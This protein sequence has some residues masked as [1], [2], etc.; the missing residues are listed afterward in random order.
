MKCSNYEISIAPRNE[1]QETEITSILL[2]NAN[3]NNTTRSGVPTSKDHNGKSSQG[4]LFRNVGDK[5]TAGATITTT[6]GNSDSN[7]GTSSTTYLNVHSGLAVGLMAGI[8]VGA[9]CRS[10]YLLV[11]QPMSDVAQAESL[12]GKGELVISPSAHAFLCGSVMRQNE[13]IQ[14]EYEAAHT[15]AQVSVS[16]EGIDDSRGKE[17]STQYSSRH[18]ENVA[19]ASDGSSGRDRDNE[20]TGPRLVS[21]GCVTVADAPGIRSADTDNGGDGDGGGGGGGGAE[22]SK[23]SYVKVSRSR[24]RFE[25]GGVLG[26]D[27]DTD[28][29]YDYDLAICSSTIDHANFA[30]QSVQDT[31]AQLF[32]EEIKHG[33][34]QQQ[35]QWTGNT[36]A[37]AGAGEGTTGKEQPEVVTIAS[38]DAM[39][40]Q[41]SGNDPLY[42]AAQLLFLKHRSEQSAVTAESLQ[43]S[44]VTDRLDAGVT[45]ENSQGF[46]TSHVS[47]IKDLLRVKLLENYLKYAN[48]RL[49]DEF[50]RHVHDVH[51]VNF[52]FKHDLHSG[53]LRQLA[54]NLLHTGCNLTA[55]VAASLSSQ[56]HEEEGEG[57][58]ESSRTT[59]ADWAHHSHSIN[60]SNNGISVGV[61]SPKAVNEHIG[62]GNP[63]HT[64]QHGAAESLKSTSSYSTNSFL[65]D[66]SG[67]ND[68]SLVTKVRNMTK[69][70]KLRESSHEQRQHHHKRTRQLD[71]SLNAELRTVIVLFINVRLGPVELYVEHGASRASEQENRG[72]NVQ[73]QESYEGR[74]LHGYELH[75]V[76]EGFSAGQI[77]DPDAAPAGF[78]G[79]NPV[80]GRTDSGDCCGVGGG[81][82]HS[83]AKERVIDASRTRAQAAAGAGAGLGTSEKSIAPFVPGLHFLHRTV[84]EREADRALMQR[85]QDC[86]E[87]LM[88]A[89]RESGGHMRQFIVDGEG[90]ARLLLRYE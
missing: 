64:R 28:E 47:V 42:E 19:Q 76:G 23:M 32:L 59:R 57:S 49:L 34:Q 36:V 82:G 39:E 80:N 78:T 24:A 81:R 15:T 44:L 4:N 79:L 17:G 31:I 25:G 74:K 35:Q 89:F 63:A 84:R 50:A 29:L 22:C 1:Q 3:S 37:V 85:F 75:D 8:D 13:R 11:G 71:S 69:E 20:R 70:R 26:D 16:A 12:A 5:K 60:G 54:L 52:Q 65:T 62:D 68:H 51:R 40:E 77:K 87:V 27:T 90:H 72:E 10:E 46:L 41:P 7:T 53:Q 61:T 48:H 2:A 33:L 55:A 30:F 45:D 73:H 6:A 9:R 43:T 86:M 66:S 21:C 58:V 67:D 83:S 88:Q 56:R 14:L 38:T 18:Q